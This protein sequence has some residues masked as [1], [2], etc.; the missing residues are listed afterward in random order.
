MP[1]GN[2]KEQPRSPNVVYV[3]Q[4][5]Q[6][7][8]QTDVGWLPAVI[9]ICQQPDGTPAVIH[10]PQVED[11]QSALMAIAQGLRLAELKAQKD[12]PQAAAD[13]LRQSGFTLP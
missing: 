7:M 4:N 9:V 13:R 10:G 5:K 11:A 2:G 1:N 8:H 3:G 12:T 6:S